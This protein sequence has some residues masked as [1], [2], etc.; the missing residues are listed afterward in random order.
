[1]TF[2]DLDTNFRAFCIKHEDGHLQAFQFLDTLEFACDFGAVRNPTQ[3]SDLRVG[4]HPHLQNARD[5]LVL[6]QRFDLARRA[7][8]NLRLGSVR[9]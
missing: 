5:G 8:A 7:A 1:M 6:L 4:V 9:W 3:C 2:T